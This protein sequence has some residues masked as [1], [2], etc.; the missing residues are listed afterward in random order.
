MKAR[1]RRENV[2]AFTGNCPVREHAGDGSYVGRCDF[3]TYAGFCPRHGN[4]QRFLTERAD[5]T[6]ADDRLFPDY[7]DRDHGPKALRA[8]LYGK[9]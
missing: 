7:P 2:F 3:A 6:E 8:F 9:R 5:L 4:V 1:G